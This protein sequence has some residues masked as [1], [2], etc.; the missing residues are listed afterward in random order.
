[1]L[2][3]LRS[4][5]G[6]FPAVRRIAAAT[7]R[8]D[9]ADRAVRWAGDMAERYGAELVLVQ[10]VS[11]PDTAAA[12]RGPL[13]ELA[14]SL[15]GERGSAVVVANADPSRGIVDAAAGARADVL[16][17]GNLG[18]S[19][20]REFLLGDVPNRVSHNSPCT[21]VIVNTATR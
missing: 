8:S 12:A 1:M 4:R 6:S 19:G 7:D 11:D 18:M 21:V 16:V 10:V 3:R 20:R 13:T 15:A 2:S 5:T 14:A 17:V 9:S